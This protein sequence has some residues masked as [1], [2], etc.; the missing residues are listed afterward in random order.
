M[1]EQFEKWFEEKLDGFSRANI[2]RFVGKSIMI[3]C[4]Q[5]SREALWQTIDS[6]PMDGS[7]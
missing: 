1:N 3:E 6:A 7:F 4:W 5:A 2:L